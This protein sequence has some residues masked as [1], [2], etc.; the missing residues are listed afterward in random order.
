MKTVR[1]WTNISSAI[2]FLWSHKGAVLT[3]N[4]TVPWCISLSLHCP[5]LQLLQ[6][7]HAEIYCLSKQ[8]NVIGVKKNNS[9]PAADDWVV[10]VAIKGVRNEQGC[11][12]DASLLA[13]RGQCLSTYPQW[14]TAPGA[15]TWSLC[16]GSCLPDGHRSPCPEETHTHT[17]WLSTTRKA[18]KDKYSGSGLLGTINL[19]SLSFSIMLHCYYSEWLDG[20]PAIWSETNTGVKRWWFWRQGVLIENNYISWF[21]WSV[22]L[23]IFT[24]ALVTISF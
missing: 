18:E 13:D 2:I 9:S 15:S 10:I 17:Q 21:K 5:R 24:Q 14:Q 20:S 12:K 1:W 22:I 7:P 16:S 3:Q 4:Y 6:H 8:S 11:Q 23:E 19:V